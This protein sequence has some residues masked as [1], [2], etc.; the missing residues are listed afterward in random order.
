MSRVLGGQ[1]GYHSWN[2][3]EDILPL[4]GEI[5]CTPGKCRLIGMSWSKWWPC[6]GARRNG[7]QWCRSWLI[8]GRWCWGSCCEQAWVAWR[9]SNLKS[10]DHRGWRG[11]DWCTSRG[12]E[13]GS[14]RHDVLDGDMNLCSWRHWCRVSTRL[15]SG[16]TIEIDT[17]R[18]CILCCLVQ[19]L[20][21][22]AGKLSIPLEYEIEIHH[23]LC[24]EHHFLVWEAIVVV[25][26][27]LASNMAMA[28]WASHRVSSESCLKA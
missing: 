7:H 14:I 23:L 3:R 5:G 10:G 19:A 8:K 6:I 25:C 27:T 22:V 1:Q 9:C 2:G 17:V 20:Q 11:R 12:S 15:Q 4:N 24:P 21:A 13:G 28:M 16:S 18:W 26:T